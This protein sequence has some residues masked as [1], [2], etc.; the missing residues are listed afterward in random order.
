[1][2]KTLQNKVNARVTCGQQACL[3]T[4][5]NHY[6]G[7]QNLDVSA[8]YVSAEDSNYVPNTFAKEEDTLADIVSLLLMDNDYSTAGNHTSCFKL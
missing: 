8:S 3:T 7:L 6:S 2:W 1:M 5:L 4:V